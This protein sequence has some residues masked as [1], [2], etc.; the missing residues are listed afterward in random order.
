MATEHTRTI[1]QAIG[2]E[3]G[4]STTIGSIIAHAAAS[5]MGMQVLSL[6]LAF[7]TQLLLA[8]LLSSAEY[9]TY[10][11]VLTW[12]SILA[13]LATLGLDTS[14]VS[15]MPKYLT[16]QN[17]SLFRGIRVAAVRVVL[18]SSG[19]TMLVAGVILSA[20]ENSFSPLFRDAMLVGLLLL[21]LLALAM[22]RQAELR[23]LRKAAQSFVPEG[24][25][26]PILILL[27]AAAAYFGYPE[28]LTAR[29]GI[30]INCAATLIAFLLGTVLL[31]K[32]VPAGSRGASPHFEYMNWIRL[33][34][35]FMFMSGMYLLMT[36][37][38]VVMIGALLGAE[39]AGIYSVAARVGT[40]VLFGVTAVCAIAAPLISESYNE[41]NAV[42]LRSISI[43]SVRLIV[44]LTSLTAAFLLIFRHDILGLFGE[45]FLEG[46]A[47]LL[48]LS[49]SH[50][51]NTMLGAGLVG[52]LLTMTGHQTTAAIIVAGATVLN[53]ALNALLIPRFGILGA[54]VATSIAQIAMTIAKLL[55]VRSYLNISGTVF[56]GWARG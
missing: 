25:A 12:I 24:V 47:V 8:N 33:S 44:L 7:A 52:F 20:A 13:P 6:G 23:A 40:L 9:G 56:S 19:L 41:K 18:V 42:R 3:L 4:L 51:A 17:W 54:A 27:F 21:P 11:L 45:H 29:G 39:E 30:I 5:T 38:D 1:G 31:A 43:I 53:I 28:L 48:A 36:Y 2:R 32:A 22:L 14:L 34:I 50:V 55:C 16:S 35:P 49:V 37:T 26:R 46:D 10:I 15:Y